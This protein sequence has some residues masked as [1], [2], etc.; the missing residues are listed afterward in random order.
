MDNFK[1]IKADQLQ[2]NPFHMIGQDWML[3]TAEKDGKV[4][5]MTASWGGLG[6]MWGKNVAFMVIRP[7]RYTKEFID[8]ADTFSLSFYD[9]SFRK[10]LGY[11]G[12]VS[13]RDEDKVLKSELTVAHENEIPYFSEANTVLL[14]KKLFAQPYEEQNFI[15]KDITGI[16]YPEKDFHILYISEI[17]KILVRE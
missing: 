3:I 2:G 17:T 13:G 1:G 4:N 11:L 8:S 5:T 10:V 15:D 12:N 14:C 6:I 16:C 7:H 9:E